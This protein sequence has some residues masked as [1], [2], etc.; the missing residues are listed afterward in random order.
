MGF[1]TED[2]EME[3]CANPGP[4]DIYR[5]VRWSESVY[6]N[7]MTRAN[8]PYTV[9][10]HFAESE[11]S[12]CDGRNRMNV[13]VNGD[14]VLKDFDPAFAGQNRAGSIDLKHMK[15]DSKGLVVL[16]FVKGKKIGNEDRDP[17]IN[18]YEIIPE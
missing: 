3:G 14:T 1:R 5:T 4:P 17:R 9:R 16:S 11:K 6:S 2:V 8:A 12:K 7:L 18:G 15:S 13:L 10:L